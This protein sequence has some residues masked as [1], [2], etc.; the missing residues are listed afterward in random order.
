MKTAFQQFCHRPLTESEQLLLGEIKGYASR[1]PED[2]L[3][4]SPAHLF[5]TLLRLEETC[6]AEETRMEYA[7]E[8]LLD[9][10]ELEQLFDLADT[11]RR[12]ELNSPNSQ[13]QKTDISTLIESRDILNRFLVRQKKT[14]DHLTE[15]CATLKENLDSMVVQFKIAVEGK[16]WETLAWLYFQS[17]EETQRAAIIG[18]NNPEQVIA[19]P[20]EKSAQQTIAELKEKFSALAKLYISDVLDELGEPFALTKTGELREQQLANTRAYDTI[21]TFIKGVHE[22]LSVTL[23]QISSSHVKR[24][25]YR[26]TISKL[27]IIK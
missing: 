10:R 23:Q 19:F 8:Y 9:R 4:N 13:L 11:M 3:P 7:N 2:I 1:L 5:Y 18:Q 24:Q 20:K 22:H 17:K 15:D 21:V 25:K 26:T 16:D 6:I 27:E 14:L 12:L